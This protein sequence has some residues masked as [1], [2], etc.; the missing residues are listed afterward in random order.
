MGTNVKTIVFVFVFSLRNPK[1][2]F[3]ILKKV[4]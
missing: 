3:F 2:K 4:A 1:K